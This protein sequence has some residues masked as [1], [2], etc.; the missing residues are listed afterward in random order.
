MSQRLRVGDAKYVEV[1]HTNAGIIGIPLPIGDND[2]YPNGGTRMTGCDLK[3]FGC[4]H[5]MAYKYFA[6][7]I[8]NRNFKSIQ[9]TDYGEILKAKCSNLTSLWM[10]GDEVKPS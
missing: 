10:G 5:S 9:C 8:G 3:D 4:C 6:Y 1:I 2:F 7:S